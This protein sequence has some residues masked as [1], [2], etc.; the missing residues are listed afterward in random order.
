VEKGYQSVEVYANIHLKL[1]GRRF[2]PYIDPRRDLAQ[3]TWHPLKS[4]DWIMP[5][6]EK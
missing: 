3:V 6:D 4:A 5:L 1:N 2:R